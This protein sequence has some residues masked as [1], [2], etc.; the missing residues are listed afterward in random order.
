M[1]S[2]PEI[3]VIIPSYN[4][5]ESTI[6][7]IQ[8]VLSQTFTDFEIVVVDDASDEDI[9]P[10]IDKLADPRIQSIRHATNKGASAARNTGIK[11]AKGQYV[12]FLDSDDV[13]LPHKLSEQHSYMEEVISRKPDVKASCTSFLIKRLN[14]RVRQRILR[15][16]ENLDHPFLKGCNV[17]PGSTLMAHRSLFEDTEVG[18]F[19]EDMRR[20]EDWDWLLRYTKE[21]RLGVLKSITAEVRV[22]GYPTFDSV[23]IA[24][25][26]LYR[27]HREDILKRLGRGQLNIFK[28]S[29]KIE[30][31]GAAFRQQR[32]LMA[33]GYILGAFIASPIRVLKLA[34]RI[35]KKLIS[36]D[37]SGRSKH[38]SKI[39]EAAE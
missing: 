31:A 15:R 7:S 33:F 9:R 35:A 24:A 36:L 12:A 38:G 10:T 22:S 29:L 5:V 8:S 13:W 14:G 32:Y 28:A 3:S 25:N 20:L 27:N 17:S 37:Y 30:K 23:R 4:A 26:Q 21:H 34:S 18:L 11:A 16:S 6:S 39:K 19:P 1:S 2:S